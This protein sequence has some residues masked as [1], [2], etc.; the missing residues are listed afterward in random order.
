MCTQDSLDMS[1]AFILNVNFTAHEKVL[2]WEWG[3][4]EGT[5]KNKSAAAAATVIYMQHHRPAPSC[6]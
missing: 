2:L 5:Q 1:S 4:L 3:A 6:S